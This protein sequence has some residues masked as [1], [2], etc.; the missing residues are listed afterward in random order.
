MMPTPENVFGIIVTD[1]DGKIK[2]L[3]HNNSILDSGLIGAKWYDAFSIPVEDSYK[4]EDENPK[5]FRLLETKQ[6]ISVSPSY[7][8]KGDMSGFH[9]LVEKMNDGENNAQFLNKVLCLGQIVPGIAHEINNPLTYVSGLLQMFLADAGDIDPKKKTYEMLVSEFNRI[10]DLVNYLLEFSQQ[11]T[12]R[13]ELFDVNKVAEDVIAM[14]GYAM[15]HENIEIIKDL[16]PSDVGIYGD[17]NMLKQVFVNLVQNARESMPN[18]GS[19]RLSTN[20]VR[21]DS[22]M[23]QFHDTGC[24]I[25]QNKLNK[26]FGNSYTTKSNGKASGMGL[27][28]CKTIIEEFGGTIDFDSKLG[29][30]SVVSIVL[31]ICSATR[32]EYACNDKQT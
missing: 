27:S 5:V 9:I 11:N 32:R 25:S 13:K 19:I 21:K 28:V 12:G 17:S 4:A 31:P 22:V 26:I 24:G 7:D 29:E 30:G 20:L 16:L 6:K 1:K 23:I 10:A 2:T 8:S 18:G 15:K 14:I 3:S